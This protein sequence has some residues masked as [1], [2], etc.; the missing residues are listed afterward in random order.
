MSDAIC[1]SRASAALTMSPNALQQ[2]ALW[3]RQSKPLTQLS[4]LQRAA[5]HLACLAFRGCL[6]YLLAGAS[7]VDKDLAKLLDDTFD[8]SSCLDLHSL[9]TPKAIRTTASSRGQTA[10]LDCLRRFPN[11]DPS[12][13]KPSQTIRSQTPGGCAM[14][15]SPRHAQTCQDDGQPR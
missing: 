14:T 2:R 11:A 6:L 12:A 5:H 9:T 13:C 3:Y 4:C 8:S 10:L 7:S 15:C 1:T